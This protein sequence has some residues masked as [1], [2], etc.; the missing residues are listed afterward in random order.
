MQVLRRGNYAAGV[1]V[2]KR[3]SSQIED[4]MLVYRF[5]Y[6]RTYNRL[7]LQHHICL[8]T[9]GGS[10]DLA[11]PCQSSDEVG[12]VLDI[13]TGTGVWAMQFGDDHPE[14]KVIGVDLSAVQ[15]GLTVPNVKFEIDDIQEEWTIGGPFGYIHSRFMTS[16][17][18]NWEDFLT[19][20]FTGSVAKRRNTLQ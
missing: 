19:Q 20:S 7:D 15:P 17:I 14:A 13:G 8:L 3:G 18:A 12:R 6:G 9:L 10:L 11:P 1:I 16:S 5:E 2:R 4:S